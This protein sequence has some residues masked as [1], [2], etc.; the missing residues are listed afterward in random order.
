MVGF[1]AYKGD[2]VVLK[3]EDRKM[4]A[5]LVDKSAVIQDGYSNSP[6]RRL[7]RN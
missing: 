3:E 7:R 2:K 5:T 4:V 1:D 6:T